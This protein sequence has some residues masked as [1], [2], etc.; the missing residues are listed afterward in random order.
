[1]L[2]LR[3]TTRSF[4]FSSLPVCVV[5][6]GSFS[7]VNTAVHQRVKQ[8]IRDTLQSFDRLL[9]LADIESSRQN[10]ALLSKLTDSAGLKASVGLLAETGNDSLA[11]AQVRATIQAQLSELRSA[12]LYDLMAVSDPKDRTIAAVTEKPLLPLPL[13][14]QS[15]LAEI[16]GSLYQLQSV[17][18]EIGGETAAT[19][20]LGQRFNLDRVPTTGRV[21]LVKDRH[22]VL[23][24]FPPA[25]TPRLEAQLQ[26][27]CRSFDHGCE[28]SIE[29]ESYLVSVLQ[30]AQLGAGFELLELQS[31]DQPLRAFQQAFLRI[32]TEVTVCGL[33][34]ALL[35][36]LITSRS[37]S[38]PLTRLAEQLQSSVD[39]GVFPETLDPG[40]GVREIDLVADAFNRLAQAERQSRAQ[41]VVA[42]QAAESAN[43]LKTEFLTNVSHELRTPM[44]GILGMTDLLLS[45]SLEGDQQEFAL[46][47]RESARAMQLLVDN[48]LDFSEFE[49]GRAR[50]RIAQFSLRNVFE[51]VLAALRAR[52]S[53]K[54]IK[55]EGRMPVD[56]PEFCL[57]D[58]VRIRQVLMHLTDNAVKFTELGGI[59]LAI[60]C[61]TQTALSAELR[62]RI[63][64]SG[65]GIP[66]DKQRL[67]FDRFT[68]VDGSLTRKHGGAGIGLCL[69]KDTVDL[70]GGTVA[71][72]SQPGAGSIFEFS[73]TLALPLPVAVGVAS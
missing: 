63:A 70:M 11:M 31:L 26:G 5:L 59:R 19:L 7:V 57:G 4:L 3:L 8:D 47:V 32:L 20:T 62:F 30:R 27:N 35:C 42:K 21:V 49:T 46:T 25:L 60:E 16:G 23:S 28:I 68:Q 44:N 52:V 58:E 48:I 65:I 2:R 15:G 67:I 66:L 38:Q 41:L 73:L 40:K 1:M 51:D 61:L 17:P 64:D 34:L 33:L 37:V 9:K 50:L 22:I 54:P 12:S 36:T 13:P 55:V 69:A 14:A 10:S 72:E 29:G 39:S 71:V 45:T 18:I 53:R 43:Q 56:V 6:I 24:G